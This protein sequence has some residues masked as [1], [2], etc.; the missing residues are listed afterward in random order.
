M[1]RIELNNNPAN[2]ANGINNTTNNNVNSINNIPNLIEGGYAST[3][4]CQ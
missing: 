2:S 1:P 3:F 4:R